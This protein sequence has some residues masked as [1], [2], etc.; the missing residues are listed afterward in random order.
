VPAA[1]HAE[2]CSERNALLP[3]ELGRSPTAGGTC[4]HPLLSVLVVFLGERV[5]L[6]FAG[7]GRYMAVPIAIDSPFAIGR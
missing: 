4:F 7:R 1:H 3:R 6:C 5:R 2:R